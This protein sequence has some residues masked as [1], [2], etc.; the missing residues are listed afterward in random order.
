MRVAILRPFREMR[1]LRPW[2]QSRTGMP[3]STCETAVYAA[4]TDGTGK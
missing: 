3:S 1:G 4:S 2:M